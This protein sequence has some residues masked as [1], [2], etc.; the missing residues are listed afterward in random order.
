MTSKRYLRASDCIL[1]SDDAE[2]RLQVQVNSQLE[3]PRVRYEYGSPI[4]ISVND[5]L[6]HRKSRDLF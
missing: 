6:A 3:R 4:G 1:S 5:K 2:Q